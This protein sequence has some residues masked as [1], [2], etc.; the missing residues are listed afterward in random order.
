MCFQLVK[1]LDSIGFISTFINNTNNTQP[2]LFINP[3]ETIHLDRLQACLKDITTWMTLN[4]LLLNSDKT[5]IVVF[6]LEALKL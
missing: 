3:D 4:V 6:G 5:D 1:S 2:Y